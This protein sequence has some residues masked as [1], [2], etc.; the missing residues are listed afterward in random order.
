MN[1]EK[2]EYVVLA[3]GFVTL[4]QGL[5]S[6]LNA[7]TEPDGRAEYKAKQRCTPEEALEGLIAWAAIMENSMLFKA[8]NVKEQ[9]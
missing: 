5:Q 4:G 8:D 9:E 2:L 7:L 6:I 3:V 1:E